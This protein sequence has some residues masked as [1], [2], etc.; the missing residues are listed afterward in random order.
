[1]HRF[2]FNEFKCVLVPYLNKSPFGCE[3]G[4]ASSV[5]CS[6]KFYILFYPCDVYLSG[7][8]TLFVNRIH[9]G[10]TFLFILS[11]FMAVCS[12]FIMHKA[13][14]IMHG[15]S[16]RALNIR[17]MPVYA[18]KNLFDVFDYYLIMMG[19]VMKN[20][21]GYCF[22]SCLRKWPPSGHI[23]FKG[24]WSSLRWEPSFLWFSE[25]NSMQVWTFRGGCSNKQTCFFYFLCLMDFPQLHAKLASPK[26]KRICEEILHK[27][28]ESERDWCKP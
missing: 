28:I 18:H 4:S 26:K 6:L 22:I 24:Y 11:C 12:V 16:L 3:C 21:V 14:C 19:H 25:E 23:H 9:L 13:L 5:W 7:L 15:S 1:M 17:S 10:G 8:L 2:E 27:F 20:Y